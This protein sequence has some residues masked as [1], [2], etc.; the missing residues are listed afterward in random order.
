MY[1]EIEVLKLNQLLLITRTKIKLGTVKD[2]MVIKCQEGREQV[3]EAEM[4][5]C[6][7]S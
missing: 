4:G 1:F 3:A 2:K 6:H 7:G 5:S